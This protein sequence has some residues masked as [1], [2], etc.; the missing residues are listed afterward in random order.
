MWTFL[1][2]IIL[3]F[4][5]A[6]QEGCTLIR[7]NVKEFA[8]KEIVRRQTNEMLSC[9]RFCY[10][11]NNCNAILFNPEWVCYHSCFF[12]MH[13]NLLKPCGMQIQRRAS[14][15]AGWVKNIQAGTI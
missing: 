4:V 3:A 8:G 12:A 6:A 10:D 9:A 14:S 11:N 15:I 5:A 2:G 1:A 13:D 7:I